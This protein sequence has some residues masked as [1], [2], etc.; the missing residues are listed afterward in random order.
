MTIEII[1]LALASTIRPTSLAAVYAILSNERPRRLLIV[2]NV[3]GLAFTV[4]F[5]L[6]AIWAFRGFN[7]NAG[8]DQTEAVAEMVGGVLLLTFAAATLAGLVGGKHAGDAPGPGRRWARLLERKLTLKSVAIAGPITHFP[9]LF[10]LVALNVII[11]H[12]AGALASLAELLIYNLI[13][14]AIPVASWALCVF[15]PALA[16]EMVGSI[17]GWAGRHTRP[18]VIA[19]S[20]ATGAL[21]LLRGLSGI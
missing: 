15:A 8:D 17:N 18:I 14:F 21:L 2:Y 16:R 19:A 20:T 12:Q 7:V 5:G 9:G 11:T 13:W 3:S 10:Y 6:L 1:F 4:A